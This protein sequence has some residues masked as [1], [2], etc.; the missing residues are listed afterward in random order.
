MAA[1]TGPLTA[2]ATK[3]QELIRKL[4]AQV[5]RLK[6]EKTDL[7]TDANKA[8]SILDS[9]IKEGEKA[10]VLL[11]L[12]ASMALALHYAPAQEGRQVA[13]S[14]FTHSLPGSSGPG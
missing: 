5:T 2:A 11:V 7:E 12:L 14:G 3:A 4:A 13:G 1:K 9:A 6:T 10:L 8:V